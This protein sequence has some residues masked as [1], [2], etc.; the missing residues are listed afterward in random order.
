[1]CMI[2]CVI[3]DDSYLPKVWE[4]V[5]RLASASSR[6][7]AAMQPFKATL[8][9]KVMSSHLVFVFATKRLR[10]LLSVSVFMT[11]TIQLEK[12]LCVQ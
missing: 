5:Q 7:I 10:L 3:Q 8:T 1:M 9:V 12:E 2:W 6:S 4:L 11:E